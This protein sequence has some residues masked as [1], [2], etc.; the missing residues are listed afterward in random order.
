[1]RETFFFSYFFLLH[2]HHRCCSKK[3]VN[4]FE[5]KRIHNFPINFLPAF[6]SKKLSSV[7]ETPP[8]E[9]D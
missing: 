1:M 4:L 7:V 2:H 9:R 6:V 3:E 5:Q 8:R